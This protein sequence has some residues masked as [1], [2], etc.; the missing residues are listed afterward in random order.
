MLALDARQEVQSGETRH[1]EV[2]QDEIYRLPFE[3]P[4]GLLGV[5][6]AL[7]IRLI[8]EHLPGELPVEPAVVD[9]D[10]AGAARRL[11]HPILPLESGPAL[12][13]A[14]ESGIGGPIFLLEER[15][16]TAAG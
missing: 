3:G 5:L 8:L 15:S 14:T 11:G 6:T 10:D 4:E 1:G 7:D 12:V 13:Q 9:D 16:R 2:A